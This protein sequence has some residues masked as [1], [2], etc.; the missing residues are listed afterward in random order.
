MSYNTIMEA[1]WFRN[2]EDEIHRAEVARD[3]GN[4]GRARVCARR[5]AGII[6]IEYFRRRGISPP[7]T[8]VIDYLKQTRVIPGLPPRVREIAEH[9]LL[10]INS[11]RHLPVDTDLIDKTRQ[12]LDLLLPSG[13]E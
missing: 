13:Y 9:L 3:E 11:L 10:R 1:D 6:L 4:E 5:A 7:G 8:S 12:L 2:F